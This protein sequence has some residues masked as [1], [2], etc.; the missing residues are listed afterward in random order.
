MDDDRMAAVGRQARATTL[1]RLG[2][3]P[4]DLGRPAAA[5]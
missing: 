5:R 3:R 1:R 4:L 2:D